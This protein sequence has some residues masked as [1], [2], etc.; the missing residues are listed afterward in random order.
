MKNVGGLKLGKTVA[1]QGW[2]G[3]TKSPTLPTTATPR[4]E[5]RIPVGPNERSDRS[6]AM[7]GS[8]V[9]LLTII[10][11]IISSSGDGDIL[12]SYMN[13]VAVVK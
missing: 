11:V 12:C 10:N 2:G 1:L 8:P 7:A 5:L 4:L 6:Y 9:Y 13:Y 3:E